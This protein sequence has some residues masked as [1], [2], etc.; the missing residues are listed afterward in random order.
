MFY[1]HLSFYL[2]RGVRRGSPGERLRKYI[3]TKLQ[4]PSLRALPT[5]LQKDHVSFLKSGKTMK[6]CPDNQSGS[7]KFLKIPLV[8]GFFTCVQLH[9]SVVILNEKH[10]HYDLYKNV[11]IFI[12]GIIKICFLV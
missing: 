8:N 11:L 9:M 1:K 5:V 4:D 2:L 7:S 10:G 3:E 6:L 12:L